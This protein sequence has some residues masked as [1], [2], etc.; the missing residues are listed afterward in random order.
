[1]KK[2]RAGSLLALLL[3]Q[4]ASA[5]T[6]VEEVTNRYMQAWNTH[7]NKAV[8]RFFAPNIKWYDL[9]TDKQISGKENVA[10]AI[11]EYFMGSVSDMYWHKSGDSFVSGDTA[12]Y[13]WVY[14]GVFNGHWGET[15]IEAQRFMLKGISTTSINPQGLIIKQ[16]DYYD[17]SSFKRA[18]GVEK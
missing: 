1:M 4:T 14:G 9:T 10:P 3:I 17:L 16:K 11:I 18:L 2:V 13:E 8:T 12:I 6:S 5:A 15:K 7:D